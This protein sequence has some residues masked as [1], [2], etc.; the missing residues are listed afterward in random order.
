MDFKLFFSICFKCVQMASSDS[1]WVPKH[2]QDPQKSELNENIIITMPK[3]GKFRKT[4]FN[5][6]NLKNA[7][8]R[9]KELLKRLELEK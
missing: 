7:K 6:S 2:P 8:Q 9:D 1:K 3:V 4:Q 5:V